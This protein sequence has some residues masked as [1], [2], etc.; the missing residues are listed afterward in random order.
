M[1]M[2]CRCYFKIYHPLDKLR[3]LVPTGS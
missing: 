3:L 2:I 1:F